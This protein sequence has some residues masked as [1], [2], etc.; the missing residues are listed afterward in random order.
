MHYLTIPVPDELLE[1]LTITQKDLSRA[2]LESL[3]T[4]AYREQK[5]SHSQLRRLLGLETSMQVDAFLKDRG[6]E[7]E[8]TSE[9]LER[10][11]RTLN[12][13]GV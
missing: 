10:D 12:R 8:Y 5:I 9:D 2:A 3:L 13:L 1:A 11:R 6:I 7:L 4:D